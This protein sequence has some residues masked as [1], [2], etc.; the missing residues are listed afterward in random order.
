MQAI[1][2]H[3][4]EDAEDCIKNI[5][6][7]KGKLFSTHSS[8]DV[9][10]Q[11]NYNIH[12]ECLSNSLSIDEID[13]IKN[14]SSLRV[15]KLL[16]SLDSKIAPLIN[17][18][19]NTKIN[20]FT[21]LYSYYGKYHYFNCAIFVK[22]INEIIKKYNISRASIYN[23]TLNGF[24]NTTTNISELFSFFSPEIETEIV[25][26]PQ[27]PQ[28]NGENIRKIGKLIELFLFTPG[29]A[30]K[31][32]QNKLHLRRKL[33]EGKKNIFLQEPLGDLEFLRKNKK[34]NLII[35]QNNDEINMV[36]SL[37]QWEEVD[38]KID[39]RLFELELDGNNQSLDK[40]FVDDVKKD[41]L[42]N[43]N[44][45]VHYLKCVNAWIQQNPV[46][47][48]IWG[49][50]PIRGLMALVFELFRSRHIKVIGAQ[51]GC[52]YGESYA[53]WHFNSDFSRCDYFISYGFTQQDLA[54]TYP[55]KQIGPRIVPAGA[56]VITQGDG[57][58]KNIDILFPIT[59]AISIF[60]GGMVR[61]PPNQMTARQ[62]TLLE[63]LNSLDHLT[64]YIKPFK[65]SN[66]TNCSVL[67]VLK[68]LKN[69]KVVDYLTLEE[70]LTKYRPRAVLMEFP[71]QPLFETLHLDAE[72]FLM[73]N[74]LRPYEKQALEQ[75][76]KRVYYAEDLGTMI[77]LLDLYVKCELPKKRDMNFFNHYVYK[78]NREE[79]ILRL[80]D[81]LIEG[82]NGIKG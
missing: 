69:L 68:R 35:N 74:P 43:L 13:I 62:I 82:H 19:L 27:R 37:S 45:Y 64:V 1:I 65:Y 6:F 5:L 54:R 16:V 29:I 7:E 67:P 41:F 11:E 9:Y 61:I 17:S 55:D 34:Y 36:K 49:V 21:P 26:S 15:D 42:R 20:Y 60:E 57:F 63:Y 32:V 56:E 81:T 12:C 75:L 52:T 22:C 2:L 28:S 3:S 14:Q 10:L 58:K 18:Q 51:H 33:D 30:L 25:T 40:V 23:L 73:D 46:L 38:I 4:V 47:L 31:K 59:N 53:P 39:S 72:I 76:I 24:L 80:I 8:V 78:D 79:T 44:K 66:Y 70:F 71:S 50:P 48:A 77:S